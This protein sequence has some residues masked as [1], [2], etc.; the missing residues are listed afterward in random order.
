[1]ALNV[2]KR[3]GTPVI[4]N[5]TAAADYTGGDVLLAGNT[6]GLANLIAVQ[7]VA[8]GATAAFEAGGAT[9]DAKVASNYAAFTKVY[10]DAANSVLTSTS[11]NMN[12]FGYTVEASPAA[13]SVV[14]VLHWPFA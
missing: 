1:M 4:V 7:D 5:Y 2:T 9:Y 3:S 12:P 10:L 11:T 8:N 13:N 6:A 14:E